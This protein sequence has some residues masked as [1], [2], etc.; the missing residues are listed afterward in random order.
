MVKAMNDSL[1]NYFV[2]TRFFLDARRILKNQPPYANTLTYFYTK[3]IK[4]KPDYMIKNYIE[5]MRQITDGRIEY[6]RIW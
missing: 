3:R 1:I 2:M 5:D 4:L 6:F